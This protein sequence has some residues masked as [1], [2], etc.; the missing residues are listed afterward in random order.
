MNEEPVDFELLSE[1]ELAEFEGKVERIRREFADR[2][3]AWNLL[4]PHVQACAESD[5]AQGHIPIN[6]SPSTDHNYSL[7]TDAPNTLNAPDAPNALDALDAPDAPSALDAQNL[8]LGSNSA[9]VVQE[10]RTGEAAGPGVSDG[11][12]LDAVDAAPPDS[13]QHHSQPDSDTD[14]A[15]IEFMH[16]LQLPDEELERHCDLSNPSD[17]LPPS[18]QVTCLN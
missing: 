7:P 12:C 11:R 1:E 5:A 17:S 15:S 14:A 2:R 4:C 3:G 13:Y 18:S 9:Q 6:L 16:L 8:L 10:Q